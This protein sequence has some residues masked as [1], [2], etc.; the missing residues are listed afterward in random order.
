M[1]KLN[2]EVQWSKRKDIIHYISHKFEDY[3]NE[4]EW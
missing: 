2:E 1:V 3:I 4:R